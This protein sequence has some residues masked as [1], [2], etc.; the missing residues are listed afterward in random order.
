MPLTTFEIDA[1]YLQGRLSNKFRGTT[2]PNDVTSNP[3]C[4]ICAQPQAETSDLILE[5]QFAS[6]T[7]GPPT[8][9][10][11]VN[12]KVT[13][14]ASEDIDVDINAGDIVFSGPGAISE[15]TGTMTVTGSGGTNTHGLGIYSASSV[16]LVTAS[17][18]LGGTGVSTTDDYET[19]IASNQFVLS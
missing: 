14:N 12:L 8:W 6:P 4:G 7:S 1:A 10:V 11:T 2:D 15:A 17:G 5:I 16:G 13:N 19:L 3:N 9:G 18:K